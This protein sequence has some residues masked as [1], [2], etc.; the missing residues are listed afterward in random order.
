MRTT[1]LLFALL[2]P[3]LAFPDSLVL[4]WAKKSYFLESAGSA[5][6]EDNEEDE[7]SN[8]LESICMHGWVRWIIDV[9]KTVGGARL[10]G[11][12]YAARAQ[13]ALMPPYY[14]KSIRLFALEPISDPQIRKRLRADFYLIDMS[15]EMYCMSVNP[16]AYGLPESTY[17]QGGADEKSYCID[18]A[19]DDGEG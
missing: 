16:R 2:V 10:S 5:C 8:A 6:A 13:H 9:Q 18:L 19:K 15:Q 11:R 3:T 17:V 14:Q 12:I 7:E 1:L 4:G